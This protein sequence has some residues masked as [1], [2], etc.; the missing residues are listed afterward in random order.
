[1]KLIEEVDNVLRRN[2]VLIDEECLNGSDCSNPYCPLHNEDFNA[3]DPQSWPL[4][5]SNE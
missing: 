1:M 5:E 4:L 2:G 3:E